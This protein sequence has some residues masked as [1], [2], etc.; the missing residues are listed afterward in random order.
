MEKDKLGNLSA[1]LTALQEKKNEIRNREKAIALQSA[2]TTYIS[3]T[4]A[5]I[6]VIKKNRHTE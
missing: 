5:I 4:I 1:E 3:I 2:N 6:G